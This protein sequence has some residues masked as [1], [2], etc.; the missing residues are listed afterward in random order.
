[1]FQR[2]VLDEYFDRIS[3]EKFDTKII[4]SNEEVQDILKKGKDI[5][6]IIS[7]DD[8]LNYLSYYLCD[9][10]EITGF[11]LVLKPSLETKF[12]MSFKEIDYYPRFSWN[13]FKENKLPILVFWEDSFSFSK[14]YS[15]VI[16]LECIEFKEK[17]YLFLH[18]KTQKG[19]NMFSE[20]DLND[21]TKMEKL[22][23]F[24]PF[25]KFCLFEEEK[26]EYEEND[27]HSERVEDFLNLDNLKGNSQYKVET[28]S[29]DGIEKDLFDFV[30][31]EIIISSEEE[32]EKKE[33]QEEEEL[34]I[35]DSA[36]K[37]VIFKPIKEI[38]DLETLPETE[39][40]ESNYA[41]VPSSKRKNPTV[42]FRESV[43]SKFFL[44]PTKK[45]MV[46]TKRSKSSS[47]K[48][49]SDGRYCQIV[50]E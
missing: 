48:T 47:K 31:D 44:R 35:L 39:T 46:Q 38:I 33:E 50:R 25:A 15:T 21:K 24:N 16:N 22:L 23:D 28:Y 36:P 29:L 3:N 10:V 13:S 17:S 8:S 18:C 12:L 49:T 20:S 6:L 19:N 14:K 37:D 1:M 41:R 45:P 30:K 43:L 7:R 11:A 5:K 34:I 32:E 9:L 42:T 4:I 27:E 2:D 26:N 40:I